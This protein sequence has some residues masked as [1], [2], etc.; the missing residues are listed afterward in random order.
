MTKKRKPSA[1]QM[2]AAIN[3]H[4]IESLRHLLA[5]GADPNAHVH[6]EYHGNIPALV[7]AAGVQFLGGVKILLG[8]GADPNATTSG[9]LGARHGSTALHAAISGS[10]NRSYKDPN[11]STE[12]DRF[13]IIDILLKAGA[14]PNAVDQ[15]VSL[16][17]TEA[18]RNGQFEIC[19]RF[20]EAGATFDTWPPGCDPPLAGAAHV[21]P[22]GVE[23]GR[24]QER[25]AKFLLDLGAPV[26][27]ETSGGV[28][29]LMIA[30]SCGSE[31]LIHL[32]LGHGADVNHRSKDGRTPLI[33]AALY[34]QDTFAQ[35]EH[36]LALRIV[37]RLLDA[38]AAPSARNNKGESAYVLRLFF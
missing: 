6:D 9:G 12:E 11:R 20:I 26:D 4:N 24:K 36:E 15:G 37:K 10:D 17:L 22:H 32:F 18:A 3:R 1:Q 14:N 23:E 34:A 16:P 13:K 2:V 31:R 28:T 29:S 19:Q 33:C 8:A 38:G 21:P 27:G 7:C 30:A 5:E 25:I 35:D